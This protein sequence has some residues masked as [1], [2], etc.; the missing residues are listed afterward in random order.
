MKVAWDFSITRDVQE[1]VMRVLRED[2][3]E[4][5]EQE[6]ALEKEFC[7]YFGRKYAV[8]VSSGTAGLHCALL[9]CG[10]EQG[11]EVIAPP[12]T[13][14]SIL[15]AILYT[16]AK[17][18]FCDVEDATMNLDPSKI[19]EKITPKTKTILAVSTAGHPVDFE[20]IVN[21]AREHNIMVVNDGA[22]ALGAKYKGTYCDALGDIAVTSFNNRKHISAAN[23]GIIATDN[24]EF[25]E[26]ARAYSHQGADL[27]YHQGG[28]PI[29]KHIHPSYQSSERYGY[30]YGPSE[31]HCAIARIQL[32][33]FI[34]GPLGPE[35]RRK[36]AAYYT[37][38]LNERLPEIRTPIEA[39]WAYHTYL[40]YVIRTRDR[41][42]LFE[43]LTRKN[44]RTFIHYPTPLHTF[45]IFTQRW[46]SCQGMFPV[47]EKMDSEV[48]TIPSWVTLT[49]RQLDYVIKS[50]VGFYTSE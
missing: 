17:P 41:D 31:L 30:R 48:L 4:G 14:W 44:I 2:K 46:G 10:V 5:H 49:R 11:D 15:Y 34:D 33:K 6:E 1:A 16:G 47:T 12:N 42:R 40:R 25:A 37:K 36:I 26:A 13:D 45:K 23:L 19:E 29:Q 22:Q 7:K 18:V 8:A 32:K 21:T 27:L 24:E 39:S 9:A 3:V 50:I 28:D 43:Y 38:L 35:R 20:P